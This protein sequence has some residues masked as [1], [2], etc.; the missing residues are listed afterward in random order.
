MDFKKLSGDGIVT[1]QTIGN[2]VAEETKECEIPSLFC[3]FIVK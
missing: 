1:S 2:I 3:L